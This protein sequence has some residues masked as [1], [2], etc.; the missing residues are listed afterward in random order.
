MLTNTVQMITVD[1]VI[2]I[3]FIVPT[4]MIVLRIREHSVHIFIKLVADV[5]GDD[6]LDKGNFTDYFHVIIG[7]QNWQGE[8]LQSLHVKGAIVFEP[9]NKK[10]NSNEEGKQGQHL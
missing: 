4:K 9:V 5:L 3:A 6:V 10:V 2:L 8:Y 1:Q 7:R